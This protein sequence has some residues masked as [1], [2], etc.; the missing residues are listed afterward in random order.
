MLLNNEAFVEF[1]GDDCLIK[2]ELADLGTTSLPDSSKSFLMRVGLPCNERWTLRF[3]KPSG[4]LN[5][6]S[7]KPT[8]IL[9]GRDGDVPICLDESRAGAVIAVEGAGMRGERFV[10]TSVRELAHCLVLYQNYCIH[11]DGLPDEA[12]RSLATDLENQMCVIDPPAFQDSHNYWPTIIQQIR[13]GL[14]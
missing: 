2:W 10:N 8:Y 6:L 3:E 7:N 11:G 9:I 12:V 5:R 14:L 1:W 4:R 13:A